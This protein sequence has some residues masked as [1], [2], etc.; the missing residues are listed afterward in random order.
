MGVTGLVVES[1]MLG[2]SESIERKTHTLLVLV[3]QG[4][5]MGCINTSVQ[6]TEILTSPTSSP[7]V[8][9]EGLSYYH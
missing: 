2:K 8:R 5:F 9:R 4:I 3:F 1:N 6:H 7:T